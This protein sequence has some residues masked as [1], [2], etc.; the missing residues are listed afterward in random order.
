MKYLSALLTQASGS[1]GGATASKN[2]G[3]NYFR[4]KVAPVQPRTVAQQSVRSN[5][6]TLAAMWKTLT[7]PQIAGWNS[8]ASGVTLSDSLG[9]SYTPSGI[10]LFVGNNRNLEAIGEAVVE[11]PPASNASFED[12]SPL[13]ATATA[14]TPAFT[15]APTIGAAPTGFKFL[16]RCTRQLSPGISYIGQSD[17]R[18]IESFAATAFASL[19][20]LAAYTAR[21]GDLV[22]GQKIGIA[23]SLVEISSGFSSLQFTATTI[24]GA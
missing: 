8:L 17:Y 2:R 1:L 18:V 15:V 4:A 20:V 9:N 16:V 24:V 11:D 3:G 5:L 6:A 23:V 10:D 14:G 21:F 22:A 13:V 12:I 19:N 7:A